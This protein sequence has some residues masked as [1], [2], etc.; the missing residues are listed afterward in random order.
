MRTRFGRDNGVEATSEAF[1]YAW[2]DWARV[3][4]MENPIGYLISRGTQPDAP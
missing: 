2:E 4:V 1:A 3:S